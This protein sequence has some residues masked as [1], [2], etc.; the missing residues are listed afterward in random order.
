MRKTKPT[1]TPVKIRWPRVTERNGPKMKE[2]AIS[3][4]AA[5]T[6]GCRTLVQNA[7]Q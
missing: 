4:S 1:S 6:S 7:S 2:I 3:T 5:V